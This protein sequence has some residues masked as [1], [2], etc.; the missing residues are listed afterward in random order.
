MDAPRRSGPGDR[1]RYDP[2]GRHAIRIKGV[3]APEM[4]QTCT[5]DRRS[6]R[7]GDVARR[8]LID[9]I[10]GQEVQCRAVGPR[11]LPQHPRPLHGR[12]R[13]YRRPDGGAGL[14]R[15]IRA[16]LRRA[17][18]SRPQP[19]RRALAGEFE[20]PQD[21][22][23]EHTHGVEISPQRL[24]HKAR[25]TLC[26]HSLD[27]APRLVFGH[28]KPSQPFSPLCSPGREKHL[29]LSMSYEPVSRAGRRDFQTISQTCPSASRK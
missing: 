18:A 3:D 15:L 14:G 1:R 10:S 20:R 26:P 7:C 22:R 11:P 16:R 13:G 6:Y 4:A 28:R 23:R 8:A 12:R 29:R 2:H 27:P 9:I 17:G 21:W 25:L 5:R 19:L 24:V